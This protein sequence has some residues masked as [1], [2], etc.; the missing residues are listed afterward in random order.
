MLA[1]SAMLAAISMMAASLSG[2]ASTGAGSTA[3]VTATGKPIASMRVRLNPLGDGL[4]CATQVAWSP[5]STRIAVVGNAVN[6]SG[7]ASGRTPG[8][9]LVYA[10]AS[11][12]LIQRLQPDAAVLALP[13]IA[14]K[15]AANSSAGGTIS[16]LTYQ[17]LT[18]TP[19]GQALLMSFDLELLPNPNTCCTS[20]Y[21]LQRLGVTDPPRTAI[22]LD[23]SSSQFAPFERWNLLSGAA[24]VPPAPAHATAYQWNADGLLVP[25]GPASEPVGA[26]DGGKAFTI[27]QPGRLLFG[28]TSDKATGA[29]T[30]IVQDIGWVSNVS[31]VSPDGHY[32]YPNMTNAGSL[33]PPSTQQA[34]VGGPVLQPHDQA[35]VALAQQMMQTPS[36]SQ[37][38]STLVAWRPDGIYLAAIA[39]PTA[40]T[41]APTAAMYSVSIYDTASG[42]VVKQ[43]MPDF[44][45]LSANPVGSGTTVTLAWSPDGSRLLLVDNLYGAITL[46]GPSALAA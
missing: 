33:V 22:W 5:D 42:K 23:T 41:A 13:A 3:H 35:L 4:F 25:A 14:Q 38:T 34:V 40:D 45:G 20:L 9:I 21:G 19:D 46:W 16:T 11:G 37:N 24:D 17:S 8:L 36:P 6:C 12:K 31:P 32:F 15:V 2:C 18:W 7:A 28:T 1:L 27:W 29:T 10:V 39:P 44:T 30:I 43:I 26:P